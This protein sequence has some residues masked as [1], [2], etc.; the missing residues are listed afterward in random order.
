[1]HAIFQR[2]FFGAAFLVTCTSLF[3]CGGPAQPAESP[4]TAVADSPRSG[5]TTP[6]PAGGAA[7]QEALPP[8]PT[9]AT[10]STDNGSDIIPPF[11]KTKKSRGKP[12]R[13][14]SRKSPAM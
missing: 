6:D 10:S 7:N 11:S 13:R 4:A 12:S 3:A 8:A 1:M 14:S 9:T 2:S 5:S